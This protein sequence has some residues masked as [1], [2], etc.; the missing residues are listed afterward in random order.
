[1]FGMWSH[2]KKKA[3]ELKGRKGFKVATKFNHYEPGERL[4][5]NIS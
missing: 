4:L 1:M 2:G 5:A 3:V